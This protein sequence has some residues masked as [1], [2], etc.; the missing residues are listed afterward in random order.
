MTEGY[1]REL[2]DWGAGAR[3]DQKME[4]LTPEQRGALFFNIQRQEGGITKRGYL[5]HRP[6][7]TIDGKGPPADTAPL[8]PPPPKPRANPSASDAGATKKSAREERDEA[9]TEL[10][11]RGYG[12]TDEIQ[13]VLDRYEARRAI[14]ADEAA[15]GG[16]AGRAGGT[17]HVSAYVQLRAGHPVQIGDYDRAPPSHR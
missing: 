5:M 9:M 1:L 10:T 17:V 14:E 13:A 4:T 8:V 6:G 16:L 3:R 2:D 12:T 15:E 11:L 7:D